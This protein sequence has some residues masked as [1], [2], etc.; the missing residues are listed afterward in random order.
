VPKPSSAQ[1]LRDVLGHHL[2]LINVPA[3]VLSQAASIASEHRFELASS[4]AARLPG[5]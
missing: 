4:R 2:S 1:E 5:K 3:G